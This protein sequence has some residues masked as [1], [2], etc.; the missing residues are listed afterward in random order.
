VP[1]FRQDLESIGAYLPGKPIEEVVREYGIADIIKLASNE[2]PQEPF[3]P[4]RAAIA[5]AAAE[6]NRY[7]D[8]VA[9]D[10]SQALAELHDVDVDHILVGPGSSSILMSIA[11]ATGGPGTSAVFSSPSFVLYP[12]VTAYAGAAAIA[13]PLDGDMRLDVDAMAAAVRSDTSVLYVC[14]PNNPTGTHLGAVAIGRLIDDVRSDVLV[15]IDEAYEEYVTASDH[16]TAIP[17]ALQRDNVVVT[18]TFSKIYG[19]A[20]LRVGYAIGARNT[21]AALRRLQLPFATTNVSLAAA[22]E[23]LRHQDLVAQRADENAAGR[24]QLTEGLR[25]L[26]VQCLDS[27]TNFVWMRPLT[28]PS[29]VVEELLHR[30]IIVRQMGEYIRIT[31]GTEHENTRLLTTMG[32]LI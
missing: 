30:G 9:H 17:H 12:I 26:G 11:L 28:S 5:T 14:D 4:V 24:R 6:S 32:D 18:R 13:V 19:L 21:I 2:C 22:R 15:V 7:P 8:S 25:A 1:A 31:V 10:L 3:A 16:T 23:A 29:K 27:Q 20:G